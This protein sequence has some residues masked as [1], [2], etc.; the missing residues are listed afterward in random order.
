MVTLLVGI[1]AVGL[2]DALTGRIAVD[3]GLAQGI[4]RQ[5]AAH[6]V[7]LPV[8][9]HLESVEVVERL[10]IHVPTVVEGHQTRAGGTVDFVQLAHAEADQ[11]GSVRRTTRAAS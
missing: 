1:A 11:A 5:R 2:V 8:G 10:G 9:A 6:V 7:E 3:A 4:D